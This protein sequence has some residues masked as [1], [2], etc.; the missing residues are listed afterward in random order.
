MLK[1]IIIDDERSGREMLAGMLTERFADRLQVAALCQNVSEGIAAIRDKSPDVVFLDIEMPNESGFELVEK[2][3]SSL[4]AAI[5]FVTAYN[6]Y[7]VQAFRI[8]ALD[9]LLKPI[10][11]DE[12][13]DTIGRLEK[14]KSTGQAI[15]AEELLSRLKNFS[16]PAQHRIGL[17]S[18]NGMIFVD[19]NDIIHCEAD[20]NY[21][22]LFTTGQKYTIS[23]TLKD[24]EESLSAFNFLRVHK[25]YLINLDKVVKY[26]KH[27]GG[28][29]ILQNK[30]EIPVGRQS[31]EELERRLIIL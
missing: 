19:A 10:Q 23:R 3:G 24:V 9:Y 27:E 1:A 17:P 13:A 14:M 26:Q 31:K 15:T 8:N 25:S 7:A 4:Q 2:M 18:L 12:L 29:I 11:T 5:V 21:T 16:H 22:H 28:T 20:D 30:A 6:Q